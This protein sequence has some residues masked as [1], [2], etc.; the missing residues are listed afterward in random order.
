[1]PTFK[2]TQST[3]T[4]APKPRGRP[5]KGHQWINGEW[6]K[7]ETPIETA[8]KNTTT[9]PRGRPP[10]GKIWSPT[11]K[12][13]VDGAPKRIKFTK[14]VGKDGKIRFQ[15]KKPTPST[16][17]ATQKKKQ[18]SFKPGQSKKQ[19][20]K[21]LHN[22][23]KMGKT[24]G[25]VEA[26]NSGASIAYLN[27]EAICE[28]AEFGHMDVF[29]VIFEQLPFQKLIDKD[30]ATDLIESAEE[31][32]HDDLASYISQFKDQLLDDIQDQN[33]NGMDDYD[34]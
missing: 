23:L 20:N 29:K 21:F 18:A 28:A 10:K 17:P 1:M 32:G 26:I 9:K 15:I 30:L 13:Y 3:P 14:I 16:K 27:F 22:S 11:E 5:R 12:K 31:D 4:T 6:V 24:D 2:I 33:L 7:T 34:E 25:I 19:L 8:P